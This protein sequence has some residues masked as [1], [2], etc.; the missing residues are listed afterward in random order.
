ME[1]ALK[2]IFLP[3][4]LGCTAPTDIPPKLRTLLSLPVK[5]AGIGVPSPTTTADDRHTA[6]ATCTTVLTDSLIAA[7]PLCMGDHLAAM[8]AGRANTRTTGIATADSTL[9]QLIVG[10]SPPEARRAE[11]NKEAGAWISIQPTFVNGLSLSKDEWRD[12]IRIMRYG[13]ELQHL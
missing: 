7:T 1:A 10:M 12:G 13:L 3:A 11:Q 2:E 5:Y 6:S 4:L 9:S 8:S